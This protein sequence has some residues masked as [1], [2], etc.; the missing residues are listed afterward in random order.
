MDEKE[1][2]QMI[3]SDQSWEQILYQVVTSEGMDPWDLDIGRLS[4]SFTRHIAKMES[5][6]FSVPAKYV[7][8]SAILLRMK[9]DD[10]QLLDFGRPVEDALAG[11]EIAGE[12]IERI[13]VQ[14]LVMPPNRI[15]QR[16][17]VIEE[18][19]SALRKVLDSQE[20]REMQ[21]FSPPS[22]EINYFDIEERINSLYGK[23]NQIMAQIGGSEV[24]FSDVVPKW[25]RGHIVETFLPLMYLDNSKKLSC[26]QEEF[27]KD[28]FIKKGESPIIEQK[29]LDNEKERRKK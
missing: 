12:S 6:D 4:E 25:E 11:G 14:P 29:V 16:K 1:I 10:L 28:I 13:E 26:R 15:V 18:L 22:I 23:I 8:I 3:V 24:K 9:S 2:M 27:F 20:R 21:K 19:I 7:I 5:M 17:I